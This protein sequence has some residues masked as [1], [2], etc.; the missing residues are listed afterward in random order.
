[1]C[2]G[3][4]VEEETWAWTSEGTWEGQVAECKGQVAEYK[5]T[6]I[7]VPQVRRHSHIL[8]RKWVVEHSEKKYWVLY[9]GFIIPHYS[10]IVLLFGTIRYS[11]EIASNK[12][13]NNAVH[14]KD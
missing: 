12:T 11:A 6:A 5:D 2:S 1:M 10:T 7:L 4:S 8:D 13:S 14:H 3:R 9:M